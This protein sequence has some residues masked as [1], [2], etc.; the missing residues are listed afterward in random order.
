MKNLDKQL[1]DRLRND[2]EKNFYYFLLELEN[3]NIISNIKYEEKSFLLSDKIEYED[4]IK[5]KTKVKIKTKT[6]LHPHEYTPDFTFEVI[7]KVIANSIFKITFRGVCYIDV[8]GEF[9]RNFNSSITFPLN[10]KWMYQRYGIYVEKVIP[11]SLFKKTFLPLEV[12]KNSYYKIG[13]R[14]GKSKLDYKPKTLK[15]FLKEIL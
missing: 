4:I 7:N 2:E 1:Y 12:K 5:L 6:L 15:M 14:K 9:T 11:N 13:S 8:K 3:N 10:Q